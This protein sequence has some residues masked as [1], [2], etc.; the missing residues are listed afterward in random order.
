M[1]IINATL[2]DSKG[3]PLNG[4][5]RIKLDYLV[6]DTD[7][8]YLPVAATIPLSNG[9]ATVDLEPSEAQRV[10]YLFE[11]VTQTVVT[12][13]IANTTTTVENII[14]SFRAKVPVSNTPIQLTDLIQTTGIV[15]DA[16]DSS[17]TAVVRRLYSSDDFWVRIQQEIFV[18]RGVYNNTAWYKAGDVANFQGSSYLYVDTIATSGNT[19]TNTNYWKLLASMGNTGAG[20]TGNS[21]VYDATGWLNATDAPSR[22]AVRNIIET[23]ATKS[24]LTGKA[25]LSNAVLVNPS[26]S[27]DPTS[28]DRSS[29]I[30]SAQW[31]QTLVDQVKKAL[32]PV[33]AI[34]TFAGSS[35]PTGWV[36][37]DGRVLSRT[38]YSALFAAIGTTFNIGGELTTDFRL[39]D[40]RGRAVVGMDYM[41][42]LQGSA[43]RV[44]GTWADA[45]GGAA[46]AETHTLT[47]SEMPSHSHSYSTKGTYNGT[48][49]D[50]AFGTGG[51]FVATTSGLNGGDGA[52]NNIQP[53]IALNV[54]IYSGI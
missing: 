4:F 6:V 53:S 9:S 33:G 34:S 50:F 21:S 47:T 45:L 35:A 29:K 12:D 18:H 27:S 36:L 51:T 22:G 46:G 39:P 14:W 15:Q 11:V 5:L 8:A 25:D 7:A 1:T 24:A 28:S 54:I 38:T 30:V 20:T 40:L 2:R 16:L 48:N 26:L 32:V 42:A 10:T 31:V 19:P 43:N 37:C 3:E 23:L 49:Q 44:L 13:V 17:L 52:H 41:S